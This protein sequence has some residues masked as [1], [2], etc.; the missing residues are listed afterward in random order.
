MS[1]P[2]QQNESGVEMGTVMPLSNYT[3]EK[4]ATPGSVDEGEM[5]EGSK[6]N[7]RFAGLRNSI[8][9]Q[10]GEITAEELGFGGKKSIAH[11]NSK[12]NVP[13]VVRKYATLV[14]KS[15]GICLSISVLF[16]L[17]F[18]SI[19]FLI[20][21]DLPDFSKA[22]A[23][24]DTRGTDIAG[25]RYS[26]RK[27]FATDICRGKISSR[28]DGPSGEYLFDAEDE[29]EEAE[30]QGSC[31]D[32]Y[33]NSGNCWALDG[34]GRRLRTRETTPR[35]ILRELNED[36][37][38]LTCSY[39]HEWYFQ[40]NELPVQLIFSAKNDD[41]LNV[42]TLKS[43]CYFTDDFDSKFDD[44]MKG[45]SWIGGH[46]CKPRS[47]PFYVTYFYGLGSCDAITEVHIDSFRSLLSMCYPHYSA[48]ELTLCR[49][50]I[51]SCQDEFPDVP[52]DCLKENIAY[53]VINALVDNEFATTGK[54]K[55]TRVVYPLN[56]WDEDLFLSLHEE[57][58]YPLVKEGKSFGSAQLAGYRTGGKFDVFSKQLISDNVFSG[59]AFFL[60][61]CILWIHSSSGFLASLAFLQIFL[62]LGVAYGIYMCVFYLPFFPFLN[63]VSIFV[64]VGIGADDVFVFIDAWKQSERLFDG[65]V[66]S[67]EDR[68]ANVLYS[69]G[70]SMLIT[71]LTTASAFAA[72]ALSLITSLKCFG[73]YCAIVVVVDYVLML[74]Y[75]PSLVII[76]ETKIKKSPLCCQYCRC[77]RGCAIPEDGS[78]R[79]LE[80]F[81]SERMAPFIIK[82][83]FFLIP[84]LLGVA[85]YLGYKSSQLQR[86]TTSDF[87]LFQ[88]EHPM[89]V[90][91]LVLDKK[92]HI[93][94]SGDNSMGIRFVVGFKGEDNGNSWDPY[95]YGTIQY[96]G[97]LNDLGSNAQKQVAMVDICDDF[98]ASEYY[99]DPCLKD[100]DWSMC[101][102]QG[103]S[104]PLE[105]FKEWITVSCEDVAS[106]YA[107]GGAF[108]YGFDYCS[109][110][111]GDD[112]PKS[113]AKLPMRTTCCGLS[114]PME[115]DPQTF[116]GCLRDFNS[117]F[118]D[119]MGDSDSGTGLWWSVVDSDSSDEVKLKAVTVSFAT[120]QKWN[121]KYDSQKQYYDK[122]MG[123]LDGFRDEGGFK[124]AFFATGLGF[125]DLQRSLSIGAYQSAGLS[126]V[127]AFVVL[128]VTS[129]SI[130]ATTLGILNIIAIVACI[131]GLLVLR[132]WELNIMESVIM[133]VAVGLSVDFSAHYAHT[134]LHSPKKG[135][136]EASVTYML[137]TMGNSVF[138]GA[139]T[140][141]IAG[142]FM[143]FAQTLFFYQFGF[144]MSTAMIFSWIYTNF[145]LSPM[146]AVGG[147]L[148]ATVV[149]EHEREKDG[150]EEQKHVEIVGDS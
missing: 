130:I 44:H 117:F 1:P 40:E 43:I 91:D 74:C 36:R 61:F 107:S 145:F 134:Y 41:L 16:M 114:F 89:E 19:G 63:L 104:C 110:S 120:T 5:P 96:T 81:L 138:T 112:C 119:E 100:E 35:G 11:S 17:F 53:D 141:F 132:G 150:K 133:A 56:W 131:V 83:R 123:I 52:A 47:L 57:D 127:F 118:Q 60:V 72:C 3:V 69:A 54:V 85:S 103:E 126:F 29:E 7:P 147:P 125:F 106:A 25:A 124:Y 58:L 68:M 102:V 93:A 135:S 137:S 8:H 46:V 143:C 121:A 14:V 37:Q 51:N 99:S 30:F 87:Q 24:F 21:D 149:E 10:P 75:I 64:V 82:Y 144:F 20:R 65:G 2:Q 78:Q 71:S 13:P 109:S 108:E 111:P 136:R 129:R 88:K 48:G 26:F 38:D 98:R 79:P 22:D 95:D 146:L 34:N 42:E 77:C 140:T 9:L 115:D 39:S 59:G 27:L 148:K 4:T 105:I 73:V 70:G 76:Y 23:G 90:Y 31:H 6:F 55:H 33:C 45:T 62:N 80:K 113:V 18:A 66:E 122:M 101:R 15:P 139:L 84:I 142:A 49:E 12:H 50:D 28:I 128:L 116:E 86:P 32:M 94:G 67:I 97:E 92:F